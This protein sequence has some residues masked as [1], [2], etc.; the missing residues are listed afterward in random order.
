MSAISQCETPSCEGRVELD[1]VLTRV[2]TRVE[3]VHY[4][5]NV[6]CE[7]RGM[8]PAREGLNPSRE[9]LFPER[10]VPLAGRVGTLP[11]W[12]SAPNEGIVHREVRRDQ[13][14]LTPDL[15]PAPGPWNLLFCTHVQIM[16]QLPTQASNWEC[17]RCSVADQF[18]FDS[19]CIWWCWWEMFFT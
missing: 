14:P 15:L 8:Y 10:D 1:W 5:G 11:R 7:E 13:V 6:P 2:C 17:L 4:E 3:A 9:G 12:L 16:A 19:V 18:C